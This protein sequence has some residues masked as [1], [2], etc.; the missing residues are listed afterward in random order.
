VDTPGADASEDSEAG[1]IAW[2]IAEL[3]ETILSLPVPVISV[4]TGEGGSG[5][6]LAFASGDVLVSYDDAIF[7][8]IGP[9]LA[10]EILFRDPERVQEAAGLLRLTA[11][12]LFELRI[13]DALVPGPPTSGSLRD[14]LAYHLA[15]SDSADPATRRRRWRSI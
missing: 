8:V 2:A 1:G 14:L 4:I 13:A 9:E 3:V 12:D 7:S 6:A 10:A 5:G 11:R 15:G